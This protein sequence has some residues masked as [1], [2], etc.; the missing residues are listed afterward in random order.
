LISSSGTIS[1]PEN[2][3]AV[4]TLTAADADLPLQALTY[5]LISGADSALFAINPSTGELTFLAAP[6]FEQPKDANTDNIYNLTLQVSDGTFSTAQD[7]VVT[8][9]QLN[10]NAPVFTSPA[11]FSVDENITSVATVTATDADLPAQALT[12]SIIGGMD[13]AHFNINSTTGVLSFV[14][15]HDYELPNDANKDN[16]YNVTIQASDGT[17]TVTQEVSVSILPANDNMPVITSPDKISI[18]ENTLAV[19]T[20]TATD[21]DHPTQPLTYAIVGGLDALKFS[22]VSSTG[23]LK[24]I[25]APDFEIPADFNKDNLYEVVVQVSDG[26]YNATKNISVQVTYRAG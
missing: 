2:T 4:V 8:V 25:T 14:A 10:D 9:A 21:T 20:L 23:E 22:I 7:M 13:T 17:L 26:A 11:S 24:F 5:S 19:A 1:I 16:I 3:S 18:A 12:Y 6:D 15:A